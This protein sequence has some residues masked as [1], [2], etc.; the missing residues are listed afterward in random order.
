M[1]AFS[2]GQAPEAPAGSPY[3]PKD[4]LVLYQCR[5]GQS[6]LQQALHSQRSYNAFNMGMG[7]RFEA[8]KYSDW[9]RG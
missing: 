2:G 6:E 5:P 8:R 1:S 7:I 3:V 9:V 4:D